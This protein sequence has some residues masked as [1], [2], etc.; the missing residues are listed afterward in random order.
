MKIF[1]LITPAS[2]AIGLPVLFV[3]GTGIVCCF[4]F[5]LKALLRENNRL[6]RLIDDIN[7][8]DAHAILNL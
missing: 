4:F 6:S 7:H 5:I 1:D 8:N 3:S 2:T